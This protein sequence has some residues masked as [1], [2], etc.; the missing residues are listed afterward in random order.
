M[1]PRS[2][3]VGL[4]RAARARGLE[5]TACQRGLVSSQLA[6]DRRN[7]KLSGNSRDFAIWRTP[8]S[9]MIQKSH[10]PLKAEIGVRF[11]E[12]APAFSMAWR[13]IVTIAAR[14]S[15]FSPTENCQ[16]GKVCVCA[17]VRHNPP[18]LV[19]WGINSKC[20]KAHS[21]PCPPF[22]KAR[23]RRTALVEMCLNPVAVKLDLVQPHT[24]G[25]LL[26]QCCK[27]R[28]HEAWHLSRLRT[29]DHA[30]RKTGTRT[31][32]QL[33]APTQLNSGGARGVPR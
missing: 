10:R 22:R 2:A 3:M 32:G 12:G 29:G 6:G 33:F 31:L 16:K 23:E 27:L 25:C 21:A 1:D 8:A 24:P 18:L 5:A 20:K 30:R 26:A 4:F 19:G 17:R 15:N 13:Q 9:T 11:P 28:L 7:R 14:F